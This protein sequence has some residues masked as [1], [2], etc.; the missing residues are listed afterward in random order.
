M[1]RMLKKAFGPTRR[2]RP[3][4]KSSLAR[5]KRSRSGQVTFEALESRI[6]LDAGP[7]VIS[8]LMAINESTLADED[9]DFSDWIEIHNPTQST[10]NLNGWSL[11]DDADDLTQWQFPDVSI[12]ARDF[13]LVFASDKDRR[14]A[15]SELHTNFKLAG[16]GEYLALVQPDGTVAHRFSPAYPPQYADVSYGLAQLTTTLVRPGASLSYLVPTA[17]DA[18]LGTTWTEPGFD[19]L[20]FKG[21]SPP[22][23][24]LITEVGT[25]SEDYAEI[26]NVMATSVETAGWVV[27]ANNGSQG[28][29]GMHATLWELPDAMAAGEVRFRT[30]RPAAGEEEHAWGENIWWST[31]GN[32]WVMIVDD[33]GQV[34]DFVAWGYSE[35]QI[36]SLVVNVNGF[37]IN[38]AD[39]WNGPGAANNTGSGNSLQRSGEADHGVAAD[40]AFT[41]PPSQG[42]VNAELLTPFSSGPTTGIGF[43]AG[44]SGLDAAIA[45]NVELDLHGINAS[46]LARIP[47]EVEDPTALSSLE[48]RMQY[49]DGF[50]AYL[51]G[52][53]IARRNAPDTLA[54]DSRATDSQSP[55]QSLGYEKIDVTDS[56]GLLQAGVNLL[57]VHGLNIGAT[58]DDFLILPNLVGANIQGTERYFSVPTPG[59]PNST[60]LIV[61]NEIHYDP[62]DQTERGEFIELHNTTGES[63]DLSGWR[64]DDAVQ[65]T[66]P[67]GASIP[68]GGYVVVAEDP[69]TIQAKYGVP[70]LGPWTGLLNNDGEHIELIGAAGHTEDEVDYKS[71]APWPIVPRGDGSSMELIHPSLDN[72][73]GGSWRPSGYNLLA[74]GEA[75]T[76]DG[77][78]GAVPTPGRQNSVFSLTAPPQIRQVHHEPQQPL[79]GES[80]MVTAKATDP[81]EVVEVLL[82][83]Q[84]VL[85]GSY[86]PA[87]LALPQGT[88]LGNPT[89]PFDPNPAYH[90]PAQWTVLPMV[91]DGTGG[92]A[93]AGDHVYTAQIPSQGNRTLVRYRI[94][95]TDAVAS[96]VTA[97]YL[98]DPSRNFAFYVYNGVPEYQTTI[99]SVRPE[100]AGYT[101]SSELMD[102]LPVYTLIT[103]ATDL[104]HCIAYD[105]AYQIPKSNEGARDRFNWEGAF[106]YNG[107]VY[108]HVHYRLRQANDRYGLHGKRSMRIRFNKGQYLVAHDNYG[109]EYPQKWRTLN[110]GKMFD[111]KD[112]GNFGLTETLNDQLW[113]LMGVPSPW[114]HTFHFRVV[115]GLDEAPAGANGQYYGDFWGM[116]L[117]IED[118]DARF[119]AAHEMADGNLYKLKDG[120]F[121]GNEL[122]RHQG[123][124]STT[125]DADF[126]NIRSSLRPE[127]S[128]AWLDANVDYDRWYAYHAVVEGVRHYD[129]VPADSHSKNRAWFFEPYEGSQYGRL[130]TLPWDSDA[131]W[132]PNWNEGIDYSKNAIFGGGGK[133]AYKQEYRNTLREFRDLV[134]TQEVIFQMIDDLAAFVIGFSQADRDRWRSA[135]ADAGYQDFGTIEWKIQDMKNF[136][137]VSWSGSTGP[138]V[139][140]GGRAAYLDSLANAEG[141]ATN[142]P[143]TPTIVSTSPPG[144]PIDQLSFQTG[145]FSDPQGDE[146]FAAMEWRIGE[147]TDPAA[148]A[149]DAD[150]PRVYELTTVWES[151]ELAAFSDAATVPPGALEV[152]HAYRARVRTKDNTGRWSHWSA[153]VQFIATE[154]AE[155]VMDQLRITEIMYH[156]TEPTFDELAVDPNFL[157]D[158]F[159]YIEL[160]NTGGTTLNLTGFEL[161]EGVQFDFTGSKVAELAPGEFVV[162]VRNLAAFEA[163]YG[164]DV[165]VAGTFRG[166]LQNGGETLLLKDPVDR[167]I[168]EFRYDDSGDWPGRADGNGSSLEVVDL[169]GDYGDSDN[170]RPSSEYRGT[171]GSAGIGPIHT[172]VIN[173]VLTHTDPPLVDAIELYNTTAETIDLT[174]WHLSDSNANYLKFR[175][176][177]GTTVAAGGY[178]VF[179]EDDFNPTPT[180][181]GP[182][183]FALDGAHGDEVW[184]CQ[185]DVSGRLTFFIDHVEFGA[186]RGGE[187]FGRWPNGSGALAPMIST[188]LD[189]QNGRNSGPRVGPV[190]ISEIHYNPGDFAGA[191]DREFVE[192]YN[193]TTAAVD[194][195][196]W[197]VRGGIEYDFAAGAWLAPGAAMV[198]VPFDPGDGDKLDAFCAWYDVAPDALILGGYSGRL[199]DGGDRVQLQRPDD[200]PLEEPNFI[201]R[202]LE[203]EVLYSDEG[204][205]PVEADGSGRSLNRTAVDVWGHDGA[206]WIAGLPTPG[207]A[208]GLA[209]AGVVGRHVFYNRSVFDGNR[210]SA[211]AQDD[212]AIA[213]DKRALLPGQTATR[214][215]YTNYSRGI[216]GIMIDLAGLPADAVLDAAA[217]RFRVGNDEDPSN[218]PAAAAPAEIAVRR[219]D[220]TGGSDR[221]TVVWE[222]LAI[223]KQ[224]LQVT[225]LAGADTGLTADDVFYFGNA[226]GEAGNSVGDAKVNAIDM[227]LA[228]NNPRS[229]LNPAPIDFHYDYNRDARVNAFDMLLARDNTTHFANALRLL[230]M[231]QA[232]KRSEGIDRAFAEGD[233]LQPTRE[234]RTED[235]PPA[236]DA[237][238]PLYRF[239]LADAEQRPAEKDQRGD[240]ALDVLLATYATAH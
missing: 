131:S 76:L 225:V 90:D 26:Q 236:S 238:D 176:P 218:W 83:Y 10:V 148:P 203:D 70:A 18:G 54:W 158:D 39:G 126:Q 235:R 137:F 32:G 165:P 67:V 48:L 200:P 173:E 29:G 210:A 120:I 157:A 190:V 133:P 185:A 42:E 107:V 156:P 19:D 228:R 15:G 198:L 117:A 184:L 41:T 174:G 227:L 132:G 195:T 231:P 24:V 3:G 31:T 150:A 35:S 21:S 91:D 162:V 36:A 237:W 204:A 212:L 208:A 240:E 86:V 94:T 114:M 167:T 234:A 28:I 219:G 85:P 109:N 139:P 143:N 189:P 175:V 45:T 177:D 136:A 1:L 161:A 191:D 61:I 68:G 12:G 84:I 104:S 111:N 142:I 171:P 146:T 155:P 22:P 37:T 4:G 144:F 112:V 108:D 164:T 192:I 154:P 179:D 116:H 25:E 100:G 115:D 239:V 14:V 188:T 47:F 34:A 82:S 110:T 141:D 223:A 135:P 159:E 193:S 58:D 49:N 183:D 80:I 73:L 88:L 30:D 20:A 96:S 33:Q 186:A 9:G 209:G 65:Y 122:R 206:G 64:I 38:A 166:G 27:A 92:D 105:G 138:T 74:T 78:P 87:D 101:Y 187:S 169:R 2:V 52:Q 118:Y 178:V 211:D 172:V 72:D 99:R 60:G 217:F 55:Q 123:S 134:W 180:D 214:E 127:R 129:F 6:V 95:A 16:D 130:W 232:G 221:V 40:W 113:N 71:E 199:A 75:R 79:A 233:P 66:F 196:G 57:A 5:S 59:D 102:S 149:Y 51:N 13:L 207:L 229:F 230:T 220:G 201:P 226:V 44:S 140:A 17:D 216:N 106:V 152:G 168:H 197:R 50:V 43:D 205:W 224:W 77:H 69:G 182:N 23:P 163:R 63:I 194:L 125:T 153:P 170:W 97:P 222:D 89:R 128:D 62:E 46:L 11:T 121:N 213:P 181:P 160:Q 53:E 145:P 56:L 7:L 202:L 81:D 151:G 98:D 215:N 124:N 119:V 8:E 93:V 147:V 103:D